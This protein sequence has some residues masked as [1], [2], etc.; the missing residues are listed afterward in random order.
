MAGPP[1]SVRYTVLGSRG[2]AWP[3]AIFTGAL[4]VLPFVSGLPLPSVSRAPEPPPASPGV[5]RFSQE[6][7]VDNI[8]R[9]CRWQPSSDPTVQIADCGDELEGVRVVFKD[10]QITEYRIAA[11]PNPARTATSAQTMASATVSAQQ[12]SQSGRL[13]PGAGQPIRVTPRAGS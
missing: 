9:G 6:V 10:G 8:I 5:R 3:L 2:I 12:P 4:A 11:K 1:A 7:Y 13:V